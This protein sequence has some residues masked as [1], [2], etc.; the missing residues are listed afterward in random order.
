MRDSSGLR[1][2]RRASVALLAASLLP[3]CGMFSS[4]PAL[5]KHASME[6]GTSPTAQTDFASIAANADV[7]Y[8]PGN[9][10][11]WGGRA[12]PAAL[13]LEAMQREAASFAIAWDLIDASQQPLL[14]QLPAAGAAEREQ[15]IRR[16]EILGSG[17]ARE[18]CRAVLRDSRYGMVPQLALRWPPALAAKIE[19]A[20]R[21]APEVLRGLPQGFSAPAGGLEAYA[22]RVS[23]GAAS[24]TLLVAYRARV[25]AQQFAAERIVRHF[26]GA[27]ANGKMVVFLEPEDLIAGQG[28]PFYVAQ[29]TRLR[30]LVLDSATTE[31][32]VPS[33]LTAR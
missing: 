22:E 32:R 8:F 9:R 27:A 13:L 3:G 15:I 21:H 30:Q 7:I 31:R 16:L 4:K 17:R 5:P 29:K 26:S 10:A 28:V 19:N 6:G 24:N 23:P 18:H 33:L 14:D 11:A 12:E 2:V 20:S 1:F 25:V